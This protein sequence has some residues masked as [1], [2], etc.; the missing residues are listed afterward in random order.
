VDWASEPDLQT[1]LESLFLHA[2][3]QCQGLFGDYDGGAT[4]SVCVDRPG[5]DLWVAHVGDSDVCLVDLQPEKRQAAALTEDHSPLSMPEF[6]RMIALCPSAKFEYDRQR[7]DAPPLHIY[8]ASEQE[9]GGW[10]RNPVPTRNVYYK[11]RANE[12][13]TYVSEGGGYSSL[14]N[15]RAIGDF[16]MKRAVGLSAVPFVARHPPLAPSQRL[17]M[18]SDGFWDSWPVAELLQFCDHRQDFCAVT[19]DLERTHTAVTNKY[20]GSC[21]DDTFLFFVQPSEP[22]P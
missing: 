13:A 11:N 18:A 4:L 17:V 2:E 19:A 8:A 21:S 7:K 10:L 16:R 22:P 9:P 14:A 1:A 15:T 20:F 3:Q 12:L 5:R 6:R